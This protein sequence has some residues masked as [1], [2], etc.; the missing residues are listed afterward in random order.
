M[1]TTFLFKSIKPQK[2]NVDAIR[3]ELLNA[4]RAEA[5]EVKKQ[6]RQTVSTW[7]DPPSFDSA[8]SL[9][10]G[11]ASVLVGPT[12]TDRQVKKFL[13]LDEGT[14]IR[15]AVMSRDWRSKTRPGSLNSGPGA[16]HVV[17]AG[18]R[19]MQSRNIQPRPGI[20]ARNFS[21]TIAERRRRP[22]QRSMVKA[23]QKGAKKAYSR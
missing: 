22:F 7:S 23:M 3:L 17:I 16:G 14:S 20:Q 11:D 2:L 4:L 13:Y 8:I 6:Y 1:T 21:G 12:G 9:S 15:W 5:T 10:G 18:R 19:A